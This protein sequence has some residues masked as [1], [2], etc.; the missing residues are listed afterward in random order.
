MNTIFLKWAFVLHAK[1]SSGL[2]SS[3][4]M[5]S[6]I[7]SKWVFRSSGLLSVPPFG[8]G[9]YR[10]PAPLNMSMN[11]KSGQVIGVHAPGL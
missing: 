3:G 4:S 5:S 7:L 2:L 9:N 10:A 1:F 11:S 8:H 6:E